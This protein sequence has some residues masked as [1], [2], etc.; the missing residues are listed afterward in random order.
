[1]NADAVSAADFDASLSRRFCPGLYAPEPGRAKAGAR[2]FE[3][4]KIVATICHADGSRLGGVAKGR[5]MTCSSPSKM[6]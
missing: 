1:V 6:T 5:T 4:K 3:Q 2:L